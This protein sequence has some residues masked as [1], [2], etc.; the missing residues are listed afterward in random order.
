MLGPE[1]RAAVWRKAA[2]PTQRRKMEADK[3]R[4]QEEAGRCAKT[5]S[6]EKQGQWVKGENVQR[7][8]LEPG[9]SHEEKVNLIHHRRSTQNDELPS[10]TNM[11]SIP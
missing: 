5:V 3:T 11:N 9:E 1:N 4:P 10:P 8:K 7:N 6:Q 2:P